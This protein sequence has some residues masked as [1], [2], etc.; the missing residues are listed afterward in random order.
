M[1]KGDAVEGARLFRTRCS[2]CHTI[3]KGGMHKSG[4]NLYGIYGAMAG[5]APW[6]M[7]SPA[8]KNINIR[9]TSSN[10]DQF[11]E[12]P[13]RF[14]PGNKINSSSK[15]NRGQLLPQMG[16]LQR[17]LRANV[18][19]GIRIY[20]DVR[21]ATEIDQLIRD[22]EQDLEIIKAWQHVDRI[23]VERIFKPPTAAKK[24][25]QKDHHHHSQQ[26]QQQQRQ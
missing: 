11:L 18:R 15:N 16:H 26:Q 21:D 19:D 8:N 4:P 3:A 9:W 20:Q 12:D 24:S 7:Y 13:K 1:E 23:W 22:G 14:M 17:K 5:Q 10:L 25:K 2:H 6:Y